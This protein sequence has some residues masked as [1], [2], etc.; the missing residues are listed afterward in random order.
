MTKS[1][2]TKILSNLKGTDKKKPSN[3]EWIRD[4]LSG[5]SLE[6]QEKVKVIV[7]KTLENMESK[8]GIDLSAKKKAVLDA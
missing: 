2:Q 6:S 7:L 5:L 3:A 4:R 1:N 8:R